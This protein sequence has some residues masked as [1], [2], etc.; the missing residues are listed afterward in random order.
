LQVRAEWEER[1]DPEVPVLL[2]SSATRQGLDELA[3][4]LM[5]TIPVVGE[6]DVIVV[7]DSAPQGLAEHRVYRPSAPRP[8][9][10]EQVSESSYR[11]SGEAVERLVARHDLDNDDALAHLERRLRRIGVIR[12]LEEH[13]FEPGDDVEIAGIEFD[14][15]P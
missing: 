6:D 8:F 14:L 4:L 2:T 9:I 11:V 3:T 1:L 5:R 10:V 7:G 13:G 15:D 12:A